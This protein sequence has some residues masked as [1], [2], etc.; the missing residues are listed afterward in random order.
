MTNNVLTLIGFISLLH[1]SKQFLRRIKLNMN[2]M[3]NQKLSTNNEEFT[4]SS[5]DNCGEEIGKIFTKNFEL[6]FCERWDN[7]LQEIVIDVNR[8]GECLCMVYDH[9]DAYYATS[10]N[11]FKFTRE[12]DTNKFKAIVK[13]AL[14]LL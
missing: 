14:K 9:G 7:K 5:K 11:N 13:L 1:A 8:G 12:C 4:V 6:D 2:K 10:G 3:N